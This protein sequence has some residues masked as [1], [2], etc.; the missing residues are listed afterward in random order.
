MKLRQLASRLNGP[1]QEDE[2]DW[3]AKGFK[4]V[5]KWK[6]YKK[7]QE[8]YRE[9]ECEKEGE[10]ERREKNGEWRRLKSSQENFNNNIEKHV[11]EPNARRIILFVSHKIFGSLVVYIG[12]SV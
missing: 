5:S 12:D 3:K 7:R 9:R 4:N 11:R 8:W 1:E 2:K 6:Y 10:R